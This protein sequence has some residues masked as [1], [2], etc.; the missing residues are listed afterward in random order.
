MRVTRVVI[1]GGGAGGVITAAQLLRSAT[2][3]DPV[4]VTLVEQRPRTGPGLAYRTRHRLHTLNNYA[5][6]LSAFA[7]RPDDLVAWCRERQYAAHEHSFLPR[8]LYGDYL[9]EVLDRVDV[10]TGSAVEQVRGEVVDLLPGR[11]H[12]V[13][14]RTAPNEPE[15]LLRL[16]ADKVVLALGN[17]PVG[18]L[19]HLESLGARYVAD[20]WAEDLVEQVGP[21][22]HV[23]L[24]GTGLTTI[25]VAAQLHEADP[26]VRLVAVSR[27]GLLP[28]TH[29]PFPATTGGPWTPPGGSL[30]AVL[31]GARAGVEERE[32]EWR[33]VADSLREY[34]NDLWHGLPPAHRERFVRH[35]ARWWE[36][37]R[38]RTS[39]EMGDR[40]RG[41]VD[42]G[43]LRVAH[44]DDVEPASFDKVV[45]CT[46][47]SPVFSSGWNPLVDAL[48][49]RGLIRPHPLG[50]GLDLD[51]DA[52]P[53]GVDGAVLPGV[54]VV[55]A[56]RRGLEWE[57]AAIP[58]LREQAFRLAR[59][60]QPVPTPT[61][62]VRP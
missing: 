44:P 30:S 15:Q 43:S 9:A 60:W 47:P 3:H 4:H 57:V 32:G 5:G 29:L 58:D 41:L 16:A 54:H 42:A 26:S 62:A 10:P 18:R 53:I 6:R 20:P 17:P 48:L 13:I 49:E 51:P 12:A 11:P 14:V 38:H 39:P 45:N 46:G 28:R 23:L 22:D 25:D 24:V 50:R 37:H 52:G 59:A 31:S 7:D 36:V 33:P 2:S 19:R 1:V 55:G 61:T 56:A 27:H 35:V 34:V 21:A 8:G 40:I